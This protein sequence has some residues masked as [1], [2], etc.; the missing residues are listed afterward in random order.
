MEHG[1]FPKTDKAGEE[2]EE[3]RRLCYVGMTRARNSLYLTCCSSRR[4]YGHLEFMDMSPFLREIDP[5]H[6]TII[7]SKGQEQ[8]KRQ[9]T[10]KVHGKNGLSNSS[11][12]GNDPIAKKYHRGVRIYHDDYGYGEI[13]KGTESDSGEYKIIVRFETGELKGFLPKYS[14]HSLEIIDE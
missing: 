11:F 1:V 8:R 6:V 10:S 9:L 4:M 14:S 7:C 3:E 5:E 13:V 12:G 2:L